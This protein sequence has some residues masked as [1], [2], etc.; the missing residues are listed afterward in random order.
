MKNFIVHL[1]CYE[2]ARNVYHLKFQ[3]KNYVEDAY[4]KAYVDHC[5]SII[6]FQNLI[7]STQTI[8]SRDRKIFTSN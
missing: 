5:F 6:T 2:I 3:H 4:K 7:H 8:N 1:G